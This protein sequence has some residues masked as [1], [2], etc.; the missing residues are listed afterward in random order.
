MSEKKNIIQKTTQ[1]HYNQPKQQDKNSEIDSK[2]TEIGPYHHTTRDRDM[3]LM[4]MATNREKDRDQ[5]VIQERENTII[6]ERLE[7]MRIEI[8]MDLKH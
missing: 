8:I 6:P 2:D 7:Q 1:K 3:N 4:T 5:E